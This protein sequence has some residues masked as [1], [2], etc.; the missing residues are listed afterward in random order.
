MSSWSKAGVLPRHLE[1]GIVAAWP[2]TEFPLAALSGV[3]T[4][5][6]LDEAMNPELD[7]Q[8]ALIEAMERERAD[9]EAH[10]AALRERIRAQAF[11][12]GRLAGVD[13]GQAAGYASGY[14]EGRHAGEIAEGARLR[15][16][17]RAAEAALADLRAGEERWTGTIEENVIALAV[18]VARQI[19]GR[20]LDN[21]AVAYA[22]LV[23]R[24]LAEF[25]I[26]QPIRIRL[27]PADLA[28]ISTTPGPDGE[29]L[30]IA[31]GR[32]ATWLAD[33]NI[34]PGGCMVEGRD[35]IIDGRIDAALE[36]VYRRL[37]YKH[38]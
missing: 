23:R 35:R 6:G 17:V 7:E 18:A 19:V 11:E 4:A 12:E 21:D 22:E 36:R 38:A 15:N 25:P 30:R 31:G 26:D 8:A 13:E 20:E 29:P 10:E 5:P 28:A 24:A 9:R 33:A 27:H 32:E 16:T 34:A 3:E 37:T 1:G 2:L 14:E